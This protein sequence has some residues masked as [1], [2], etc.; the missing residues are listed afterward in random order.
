MQD[1]GKNIFVKIV[2]LHETTE[3]PVCDAKLL[4]EKLKVHQSKNQNLKKRNINKT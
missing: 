2:I 4:L 1:E 3:F